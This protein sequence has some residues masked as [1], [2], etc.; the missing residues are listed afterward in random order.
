MVEVVEAVV[1]G[2]ILKVDF[3]LEDGLYVRGGNEFETIED[4]RRFVIENEN[5]FLDCRPVKILGTGAAYGKTFVAKQYEGVSLCW[6]EW[7]DDYHSGWMT[8]KDA[9]A[10]LDGRLDEVGLF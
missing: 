10:Y 3:Y 9:Q 5:R 6:L 2:V 7:S 4:A 1:N 8:E